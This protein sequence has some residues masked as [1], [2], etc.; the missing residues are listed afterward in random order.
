MNAE[1]LLNILFESPDAYGSCD[2]C[3]SEEVGI[4][5]L[6]NCEDGKMYC[7]DCFLANDFRGIQWRNR[8]LE[9][10]EEYKEQNTKKV[11]T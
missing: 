1:R 6:P 5:E 9:W 8:V 11:K 2:G 10:W 4:I 3:D 7:L